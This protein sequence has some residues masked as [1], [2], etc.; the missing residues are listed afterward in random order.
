MIG[1]MKE[2]EMKEKI[3]S[4]IESRLS[5]KK[6]NWILTLYFNFRLLSFK[7]AM[8]L[9]IYIYGKW[10]FRYLGGKIIINSPVQK[11][12]IKIGVNLAGYVSTGKG[13]IT[14]FKNSKIIFDGICNI[15]QGCSLVVFTDA[16]LH[17]GHKVNLGD[18]VKIICSKKIYI[19]KRTDITWE[20]QIS[21]Y[22]FHFIRDKETNLIRRLQM[23]VHIG[24]Y[25]WI[26]N[27]TSVMPGVKLPD[28]TIVTSNSLINKDYVKTGVKEF[29]M[30]AG[31]PAK[32]V[33]TNCSRIYS[34]EAAILLDDFFNNHFDDYVS[35]EILK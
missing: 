2:F 11:G 18:S 10:V 15:S 5:T 27:R 35:S 29:S 34:R 14:L 16:V 1:N 30:L 21:D 13:T 25:N 31:M 12:M 4:Y 8:K 7:Q 26:G 33:K 23:P 24:E 28:Y 6:V 32:I 17:F 19:G 3:L 9:P 20:S 22:N